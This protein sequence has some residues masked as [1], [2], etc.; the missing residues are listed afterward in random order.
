MTN[1]KCGEVEEIQDILDQT[2]LM[3]ED[4]SD[5]TSVLVGRTPNNDKKRIDVTEPALREGACRSPSVDDMDMMEDDVSPNASIN[6]EDDDDNYTEEGAPTDSDEE[7][8]SK[9]MCPK[10]KSGRY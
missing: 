6:T 2:T 3:E 8:D 4:F 1:Y 5:L 7:D 9:K 10:C